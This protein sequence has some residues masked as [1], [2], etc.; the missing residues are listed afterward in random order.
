[1]GSPS[2]VLVDGD[3]EF[4]V[5]YGTEAWSASCE[6]AR[7]HGL[8]PNRIPAGSVVERDADG[9]RIAFEEY[10]FDTDGEL[11]L[12]ADRLDAERIARIEQGEA[13]PLPFPREVTG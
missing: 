3:R 6:W 5:E 7:F 9:R 10:V 1:M 4:E 2:V 12:T 11:V 8:D 13:P